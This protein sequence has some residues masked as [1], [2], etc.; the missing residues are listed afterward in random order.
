MKRPNYKKML[1]KQ[2]AQKNRF[3]EKKQRTVNKNSKKLKKK[4]RVITSSADRQK[5]LYTCTKYVTKL[6]KGNQ[7]FI[8]LERSTVLGSAYKR[9]S[10]YS[11]RFYKKFH[12]EKYTSLLNFTKKIC[13][14]WLIFLTN[15]FFC[16]RF[17]KN[18]NV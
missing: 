18:L 1:K 13:K 5:V 12:W 15:V 17:R 11:R 8:T 14:Y 4:Q 7:G 10:L 3:M 9:H 16:L 6:G 2:E